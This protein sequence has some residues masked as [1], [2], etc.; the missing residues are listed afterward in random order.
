MRQPFDTAFGSLPRPPPLPPPKS[1]DASRAEENGPRPNP[2]VPVEPKLD[3]NRAIEVLRQYLMSTNRT[4][5]V[6]RH[7]DVQAIPKGRDA[8][9]PRIQRVG[10][11]DFY[12]PKIS[13]LG[14][15]S[16]AYVMAGVGSGM[17]A[18]AGSGRGSDTG[19]GSRARRRPLG[20]E[21]A[22]AEQASTERSAWQSVTP[23][24][25]QP[26]VVGSPTPQG[27]AVVIP[28]PVTRGSLPAPPAMRPSFRD[29]SPPHAARSG[30]PRLRELR[31]VLELIR[32]RP[33]FL[34][35]QG[36]SRASR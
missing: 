17:G 26:P 16:E 36:S 33:T 10:A 7:D 14:P 35:S 1:G 18:D 2:I 3:L 11:V 5:R 6:I 27:G 31:S 20:A 21:D 9:R 19:A 8:F 23:P 12:D 25:P 30:P 29:F 13:P 28:F 34:D 22:D 24:Q 32:P 15:Y 4:L